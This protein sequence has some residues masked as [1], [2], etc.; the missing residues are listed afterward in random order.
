M[1]SKSGKSEESRVAE[2]QV[3]KRNI[4]EENLDRSL[5]SGD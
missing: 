5:G 1:Q 3:T 4:V 2:A